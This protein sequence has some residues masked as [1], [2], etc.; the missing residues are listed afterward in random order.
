MAHAASEIV[1]EAGAAFVVDTQVPTSDGVDA[2]PAPLV[3]A[4]AEGPVGVVPWSEAQAVIASAD[5]TA[6]NAAENLFML[7]QSDAQLGPA[8]PRAPRGETLITVSRPH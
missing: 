1:V 3:P 4:A 7:P 5:A 6:S 2:V 8:L